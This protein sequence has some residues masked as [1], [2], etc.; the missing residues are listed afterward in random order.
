MIHIM[1][2][3]YREAND[4]TIKQIADFLYVNENSYKRVE[5]SDVEL[6][7]SDTELLADLYGINIMEFYGDYEVKNT[8][9]KNLSLNKLPTSDLKEI[10]K[11]R[12]IIKNY[13][14]IQQLLNKN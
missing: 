14:K 6:L 3:K 11:F 1:L 7:V 12:S 10:A 4:L 5:S 9:L 2:K 8:L 13:D